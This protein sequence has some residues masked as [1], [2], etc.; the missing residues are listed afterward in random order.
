MVNTYNR[1]SFRLKKKWNF[2][3]W[4]SID[5]PWRYNAEVKKASHQ[6][7]DAIWFHSDE[8]HRVVRFIETKNRTV[9]ARGWEKKGLKGK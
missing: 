1:I 9:V 6:R 4:Y 2:D 8:V 7:A 3:V 5:E